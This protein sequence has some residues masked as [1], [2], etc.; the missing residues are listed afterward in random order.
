MT[1]EIRSIDRRK[2]A[3]FAPG[4]IA[5]AESAAARL[6]QTARRLDTIGGHDALAVSDVCTAVVLTVQ[7]RDGVIHHPIEFTSPEDQA[8]A[9]L[10][11]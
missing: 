2:A 5:L 6:G 3:A 11:P 10:P 7:S 9:E 1:S 4:F 8:V